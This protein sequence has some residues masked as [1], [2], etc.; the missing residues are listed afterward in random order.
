MRHRL[1]QS[2]VDIRTKTMVTLEMLQNEFHDYE[3]IA[4]TGAKAITSVY[5]II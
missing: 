3:A 5:D 1:V 4:S 2:G